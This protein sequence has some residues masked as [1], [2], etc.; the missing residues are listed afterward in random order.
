MDFSKVV[1]ER[2]SSRKFL[3]KTIAETTLK[4]IVREAQR[5]PSWANAQ[6]WEPII[7]TGETL[8][9]IKKNHMR[10]SNQGIP[11][12]SDMETAHR[13]EWADYARNN[14]GQWNNA[15]VRHLQ[16]NNLPTYEYGETQTSLFQ[17]AA[18]VYL[19]VKVPLNDWEIFDM[20]AFGQ[21]LMLSAANRGIQSIPAYEVVRYPDEL[22]RIFNL[23]NDQKF[24]MGVALGYED[25]SIIND[26]RTTRDD[27][28][29]ILRMER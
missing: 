14:I 10:L 20:G 26:F 6:P 18:I 5:T 16:N 9:T 7:A 23:G 27:E 28:K 25:E 12:D 19:T 4:E 3:N 11:G 8:Q 24:L 13:T 29:N 15:L 17:A 2:H 21:T 22:R 1:N